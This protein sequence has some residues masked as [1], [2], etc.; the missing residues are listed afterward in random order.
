MDFAELEIDLNSPEIRFAI[1]VIRSGADLARR[2][3]SASAV[4]SMTKTDSSPVTVADMGIQAVTGALLQRY[5][6]HEQ[7]VG[8]ENAA[9]LRELEAKDELRVITGYVSHFLKDANPEKVCHWIDHGANAPGERFWALDPIDGTKGFLRGGH[10]A[11]ALA[12][13]HQG[14][15]EL[16]ALGCPEL[17]LPACGK[18]HQG[19]M[20]LA[21]RGKGCWASPLS[22]TKQWKRLHVSSCKDVSKAR[23]LDSFDPG[24]K[25]VEKNTFIK[26]KLG[27][28]TDPITLDSQTKHAML[29]AGE[30]EIFFRTLPKKNP[31]YR[32]KIWDV[33]PGAFA[34]EEAGGRVTDLTGASIDYS[35]GKILTRNPGFLATNGPF[36]DE[37]LAAIKEALAT[38]L[39]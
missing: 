22:D 5:L 31:N 21:A 34:I 39:K 36:H 37:I 16:S 3:R 2:V 13:I 25:N 32:E 26:Q 10:Y 1:E 15:V 20:L 30:A 7:L 38:L 14:K 33:A 12:L 9:M 6:P 27:I 23:I 24:H 28:Q 19:V 8:E 29:A 18:E 11:T 17:V 4:K 35:A